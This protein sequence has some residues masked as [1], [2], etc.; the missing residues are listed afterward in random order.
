MR[1][2]P[3]L[4]LLSTP[5]GAACLAAL[6]SAPG[7]R[8]QAPPPRQVAIAA[9]VDSRQLPMDRGAAAVWQSLQKLHTR[10]SLLMVTAHPDDEDGGLLATESRGR[11]VRAALLTLNRGEGGENLM[12]DDF[13]DALGLVRTQ[14]LLAADR[15]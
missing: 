8:A 13:Y 5:A 15:Y 2:R 7:L 3:G 10:A 9:S 1:L 4:G 11:G 6:L 12:S 14:E